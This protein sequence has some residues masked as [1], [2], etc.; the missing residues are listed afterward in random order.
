MLLSCSVMSKSFVTPWTVAHQASLFMGFS[1]QEYWSG[2]PFPS[3]TKWYTSPYWVGICIISP[4]LK[5]II[6][7]K[8]VIIGF[9]WEK[10][11]REW[12][13]TNIC[14]S[15]VQWLS[16]VWLFT[17][18][19]TAARQASLSITNTWSLLKLMSIEL[20]IPFNHLILC[21]SLLF[22]PSVFPSIRVF[23]KES[24]LHIRWP[25]Y[26]SFSFS[27]P[28]NIQDWFPLGLTGLFSLQSKG[29]SKLFSNTTVQIHQFFCSQLSKFLRF[30]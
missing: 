16:C 15:S 28:M 5:K 18:P 24:V 3:P 10:R 17:T 27:L 2:F 8:K 20:V 4:I 14:F 22:L 7:W 25:K 9:L 26:W 23:S 12:E 11:R 19:W 29:L 6:S 13:G 30:A 21:H 1:R